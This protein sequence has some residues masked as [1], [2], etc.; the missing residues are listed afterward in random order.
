MPRYD[1][2]SLHYSDYFPK[3]LTI[4]NAAT[5]IGMFITWCVEAE[6]VSDEFI[7]TVGEDNIQKNLDHELSGVELLKL[8]ENRFNDEHLT[9]EG[10]K[11][12][13]AYYLQHTKFAK[14]YNTYV[15]DYLDTFE[16]YAYENGYEYTSLYH[17]EDNFKNY[18]VIRDVITGRLGDFKKFSKKKWFSFE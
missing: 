11:F 16:D 15:R 2:V 4:D 13:E 9:E 1:A 5:H 12:A 17:V 8:I 6:F 18:E 3:E 14:K 7:A 10:N